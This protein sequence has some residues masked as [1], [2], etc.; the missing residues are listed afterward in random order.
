MYALS[1]YTGSHE[2]CIS[3]RKLLRRANFVVKCSVNT[4]A[5]SAISG[6]TT[7]RSTNSYPFDRFRVPSSHHCPYCKLCRHGRGLNID[8]YHCPTCNICLAIE[9]KDRH[10]C[11]ENKLFCNCPI[12]GE[13]LQTSRK[14][15][16]FLLCGHGIHES[17]LKE[18]LKVGDDM[19]VDRRRTMCA[20]CVRRRLLMQIEYSKRLISGWVK[21]RCRLLT[22]SG[23]ERFSAMTVRREAR[24]RSISYTTR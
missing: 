12:C 18:Y 22:M 15:S 20:R 5:I 2:C 4:T 24:C 19:K 10:L 11:S 17:C 23:S 3:L 21:I 7:R 13:W 8:S 1:S 6:A 14:G 9:G 16:M